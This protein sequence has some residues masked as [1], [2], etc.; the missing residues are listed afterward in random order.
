M[1]GSKT[2]SMTMK[3]AREA[4]AHGRSLTDVR[5]VR[6]AGA[7]VWDG[8]HEED[9]P[10]SAEQLKQGVAEAVRRR[11]RPSGSAKES[12]TI[13]FDRDVLEAFKAQGPGWQTRINAVL[14]QWLL[15]HGRV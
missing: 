14:K 1:A 4:S 2:T 8:Q 6:A 11:G 3:A 12:T 15:K 13:R 5:K 9:Q 10:L 7:Y